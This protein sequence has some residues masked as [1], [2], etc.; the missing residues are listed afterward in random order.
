MN[1]L[2]K[3]AHEFLC[4]VLDQL[5]EDADKIK[6]QHDTTNTFAQHHQQKHELQM[7]FTNPVIENFEFQVTHSIQCTE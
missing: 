5:K 3:D 7:Q 6:K 1:Y 4:Q 2:K